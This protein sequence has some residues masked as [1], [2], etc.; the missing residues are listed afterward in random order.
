MRLTEHGAQMTQNLA[1]G[2]H[3]RKRGRPNTD[4]VL[5][6][7]AQLRSASGPNGRAEFA[8]E[9]LAQITP[10]ALRVRP[11]LRVKSRP[12]LRIAAGPD[13]RISGSVRERK[14][15]A[16]ADFERFSE[17]AEIWRT[18]WRSG[19]DSN[20]R[21]REKFFRRKTSAIA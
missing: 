3:R 18:V 12:S 9:I 14:S 16:H 21:C 6:L 13:I 15:R 17:M 4:R 10:S 19:V 20:R 7:G 8:T 2:E 11:E 5:V 1:I